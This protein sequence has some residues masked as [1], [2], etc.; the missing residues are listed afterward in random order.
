MIYMNE[1]II[2][3]GRFRFFCKN[4]DANDSPNLHVTCHSSYTAHINWLE[5]STRPV[6]LSISF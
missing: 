5:I 2:P 6:F 1:I 3:K 4:C